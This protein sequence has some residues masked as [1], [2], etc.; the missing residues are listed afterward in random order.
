MSSLNLTF[1]YQDGYTRQQ[2]LG[3][4]R[5]FASS[6]RNWRSHC[7]CAGC[8]T[9]SKS[10]VTG[11]SQ[12]I[13]ISLQFWRSII[14]TLACFFTLVGEMEF[15]LH[16]IFEVLGLSVWDLPYVEYIPDAEELH[17]VKRHAPQV[18][19]TYWKVLYHFHICAQ[20]IGWRS[21]GVKQMLWANYLFRG[22]REKTGLVSL[23]GG[24][25][26]CWDHREDF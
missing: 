1:G 25:H 18:Y 21:E 9:L 24:H 6:S 2:S 10:C 13:V 26:R 23:T 19:E 12:V 16:E 11:S 8:I 15:A 4:R 3:G 7:S 14:Q 20:G 5:W 17:L 22:L